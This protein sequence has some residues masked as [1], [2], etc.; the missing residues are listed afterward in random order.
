M[1]HI[2]KFI[3]YPL[4]SINQS[5]NS[6]SYFIPPLYHPSIFLSPIIHLSLFVYLSIYL[7]TYE[8]AFIL[9]RLSCPLRS[10]HVNTNPNPELCCTWEPS[11]EPPLT[12]SPSL[13]SL[14]CL[15][16]NYH[17]R[18]DTCSP[19]FALVVPRSSTLT[20]SLCKV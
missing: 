19:S 18:Q 10:R 6:L 14:A 8:L 17:A 12:N 9:R 20:Q 2:Y 4:S 1:F 5:V 15:F 7:V 16:F 11:S 3:Y 13:P